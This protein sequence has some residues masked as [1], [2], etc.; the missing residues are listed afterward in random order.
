MTFE[1][2]RD[3]RHFSVAKRNEGGSNGHGPGAAG[4]AGAGA[5]APF[6]VPPRDRGPLPALSVSAQPSLHT[7]S[8]EGRSCAALSGR[9]KTAGK[10]GGA[11]PDFGGKLALWKG[12]CPGMKAATEGSS[13]G[14]SRQ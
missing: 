4:G 11:H 3:I 13:R 5:P 10:A 7:G 9:W 8:L 14:M 6:H 2:W 1:E 12:Q